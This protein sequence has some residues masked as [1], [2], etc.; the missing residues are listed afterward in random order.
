MISPSWVRSDSQYVIE[1]LTLKPLNQVSQAFAQLQQQGR[2]TNIS[3]YY[4]LVFIWFDVITR[5][6]TFPH[7]FLAHPLFSTHPSFG[8]EALR[9]LVGHSK[10]K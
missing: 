5:L 7:K 4:Y 8:H 2:L 1:A 9:H 6:S 10:R 3:R